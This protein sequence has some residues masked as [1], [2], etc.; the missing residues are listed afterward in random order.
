VRVLLLENDDSYSWNVVDCLRSAG[1][2]VR[3]I[4]GRDGAGIRACLH[5][6][7]ALVIGPGPLDPQRAGL[8]E[9]LPALLET[10]LPLLGICL[11]HQALGLAFGARLIRAEPAHGLLTQLEFH[12]SRFFA[13]IRGETQAMR[14]HSLALAGVEAPLRT[15]ASTPEGVVMAIEHEALPIAGLQFHPD[16]FATPRG[17]E[18]VASFLR[19]AR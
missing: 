12:G 18:M 2:G 17:G 15:I 4:S 14:Y 19:S 3:V 10:R 13:S 11:G 9:I 1:A 7:D 8:L 6:V 5:A 16:S